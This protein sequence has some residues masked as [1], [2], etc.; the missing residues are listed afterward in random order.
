MKGS[1]LFV[2]I[3]IPLLFFSCSQDEEELE[4]NHKILNTEEQVHLKLLSPLTECTIDDSCGNPGDIINVNFNSDFMPND[5]NWSIQNG[6]LSIISGQGTPRLTLFLHSDFEGGSVFAIGSGDGGIVCSTTSIV[7]KCPA[8]PNCT[9]PTLMLLEQI[10]GECQGDIF[11][12][13]AKLN[14]STNNGSYQWIARQD[15]LIIT[16]QGTPK[17][18]IQSPS[19]RGFSVSVNHINSCENT[20]ING[21]TLAQYDAGCS[22]GGGGFGF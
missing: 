9:P 5:V 11:V 6:N 8:T 21:F 19:T 3:L 14:G 12:F 15:A 10:S 17:V 4:S 22:G 2:L 16:G 18:R 1:Q 13:E 20:S 7:T